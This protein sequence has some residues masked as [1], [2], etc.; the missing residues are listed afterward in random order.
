MDAR[1]RVNLPPAH[2]THHVSIYFLRR[3]V[4]SESQF[5]LLLAQDDSPPLDDSRRSVASADKSRAFA[6]THPQ[7]SITTVVAARR[8]GQ[9]H[10]EDAAAVAVALPQDHCAAL[11]EA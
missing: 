4:E 8:L 6:C 11:L 9:R 2:N 3:T 5:V 1:A 10:Q 7:K